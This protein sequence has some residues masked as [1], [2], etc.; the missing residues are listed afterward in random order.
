MI[1]RIRRIEKSVRAARAARMLNEETA[2]MVRFWL[3]Q[4][5][6]AARLAEKAPTG[7]YTL[8]DNAVSSAICVAEETLAGR[9]KSAARAATI[10]N[11]FL[12]SAQEA[13]KENE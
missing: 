1:K 11:R 9:P 10:F 8:A 2:I 6:R 13:M 3:R 7:A 12:R 5:A 4:A